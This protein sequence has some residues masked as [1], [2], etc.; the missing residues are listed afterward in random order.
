MYSRN[1]YLHSI[2]LSKQWQKY[3]SIDKKALEIVRWELGRFTVPGEGNALLSWQASAIRPKIGRNPRYNST[4]RNHELPRHCHSRIH[5]TLPAIFLS[6]HP[7]FPVAHNTIYSAHFAKHVK[8]QPSVF[9]GGQGA[10]ATQN[11]VPWLAKSVNARTETNINRRQRAQN[12]RRTGYHC[13]GSLWRLME[14]EYGHNSDTAT[15]VRDTRQVSTVKDHLA[16]PP[17]LPSE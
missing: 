6:H 17:A 12:G 15:M 10:R 11:K 7:R 4:R 13:S 8:T 1:M 9:R 3:Y 14:R 16:G 2:K 5:D